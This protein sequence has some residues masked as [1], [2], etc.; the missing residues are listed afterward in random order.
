[1][2]RSRIV[3]VQ[4]YRPLIFALRPPPVPIV[5]EF[6]V[7][8]R[9]VGF[10]QRAIYT[11]CFGRSVFRQRENILWRTNTLTAQKAVA[12]GESRVGERIIWIFFYG[13]PEIVNR[14]LIALFGPL[15]PIKAAFQIQ[16]K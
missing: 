3:R 2:M 15:V 13:L 6:H 4:C 9:S 16:L 14:S 1:M 11:D 10:G 7:S 8:Q 12:V 5:I